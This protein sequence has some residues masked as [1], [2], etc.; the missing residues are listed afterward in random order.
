V[1]AG[2]LAPTDRVDLKTTSSAGIAGILEPDVAELVLANP[3]QVRAICHANVKTDRFDA[4][5]LAERIGSYGL[6]I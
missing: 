5:T 1:F 4:R 6:S 2:S 3:M